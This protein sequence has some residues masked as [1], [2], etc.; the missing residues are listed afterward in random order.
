MVRARLSLPLRAFLVQPSLG[1][2][3]LVFFRFG[4]TLFF[5]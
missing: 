5:S 2:T 3:F 4:A 1:C